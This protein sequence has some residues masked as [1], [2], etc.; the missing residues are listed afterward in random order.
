MQR[1]PRQR[2]RLDDSWARFVLLSTG[3]TQAEP[4]ENLLIRCAGLRFPRRNGVMRSQPLG[5]L[6]SLL[7]ARDGRELLF[8]HDVGDLVRRCLEPLT[9]IADVPDRGVD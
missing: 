2:L 8:D 1:Q 9:P 7:L 3:S 6:Q 5:T 4:A